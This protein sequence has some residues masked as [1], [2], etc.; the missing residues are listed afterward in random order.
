MKLIFID[1]FE[2]SSE[3]KAK[4]FKLSLENIHTFFI[5]FE[6]LYLTVECRM[7]LSINYT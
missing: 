1:I 5:F 3:S 4:F 6:M 2:V 7:Q